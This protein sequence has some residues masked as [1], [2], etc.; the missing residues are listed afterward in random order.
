MIWEYKKSKTTDDYEVSLYSEISTEPQKH[1]VR[2]N[3]FP[4]TASFLFYKTKRLKKEFTTLQ[5]AEIFYDKNDPILDFEQKS[6]FDIYTKNELIEYYKLSATA[7]YEIKTDKIFNNENDW[8]EFKTSYKGISL[9]KEEILF[10][11]VLIKDLKAKKLGNIKMD[12][13]SDFYGK[14][15]LTGQDVCAAVLKPTVL[16]EI[17][18]SSFLVENT[19]TTQPTQNI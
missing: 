3:L 15:I 14:T 4:N 1:Q 6:I 12:V 17:E 16:A 11:E 8:L 13:C 19:T 2:L 9:E 10:C 18:I 7:Q 5:E